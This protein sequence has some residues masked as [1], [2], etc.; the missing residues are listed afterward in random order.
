MSGF[1]PK[2]PALGQE[3]QNDVSGGE[4][5]RAFLAHLVWTALQAVAADADGI[6]AEQTPGVAELVVS[7]G[8]GTLPCPRNLTVTGTGTAADVPADSVVI[9]GTN[10]NDEA[11]TE[12]FLFTVNDNTAI[13]GAKAFKTVTKVTFPAGDGADW[14]ATVGWGDKLGLPYMLSHN[15]ILAAY[16]NNTLEGTAPTVVVDDDEIEKNTIDLHS[17]LNGTVVD[18]YVIV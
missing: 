4:V 9:E 10:I 2:N 7:T 6:L 17:A 15:T 18:A 3:I 8:F 14:Q 13:V 11:I 1:Y 12:S 16:L 5:D